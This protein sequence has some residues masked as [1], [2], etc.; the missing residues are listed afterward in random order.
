M[1]IRE[2]KKKADKKVAVKRGVYL[3]M[4]GWTAALVDTKPTK[5]TSRSPQTK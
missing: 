5:P 2:A 4:L 3:D 1:G